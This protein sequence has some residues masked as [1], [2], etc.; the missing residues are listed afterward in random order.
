MGQFPGSCLSLGAPASHRLFCSEPSPPRSFGSPRL[1]RRMTWREELARERKGGE[2]RSRRGRRRS[3]G[4]GPRTSEISNL[5]VA[6]VA[7]VKV[8]T[9]TVHAIHEGPSRW[10]SSPRRMATVPRARGSPSLRNHTCGSGRRSDL[11]VPS[12]GSAAA[13]SRCAL[14][15]A[16]EIESGWS[17]GTFASQFKDPLGATPG[18]TPLGSP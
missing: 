14:M 15:D 1:P 2:K 13:G 9:F 7:A 10:T 3:Q 4:K 16:S 17:I 18:R 6:Q 8:A 11:P 5:S 12:P